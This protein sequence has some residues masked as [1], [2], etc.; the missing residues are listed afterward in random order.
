VACNLVLEHLEDLE[1]VFAEAV[2]CLAPGGTLWVSELHPFRQ[3]LGS[4][5]RFETP[6]GDEVRVEAHVHH[7]SDFLQAAARYDL[8]L[9]T[10]EEH[11]HPEDDEGKP[12]RLLT[13][14]FAGRVDPSR[15][16]SPQR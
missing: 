5:A 8:V 15:S 16:T 3:Y 4:Q 12:P 2:R 1:P 13:L 14:R 9:V 6:G 11:W 10:L 7:V